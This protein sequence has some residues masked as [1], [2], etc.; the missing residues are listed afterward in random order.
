MSTQVEGRI[1]D[2]DNGPKT[3]LTRHMQ[4]F[5]GQIL[6]RGTFASDEFDRLY[7]AWIRARWLAGDIWVRSVW[8]ECP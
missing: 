1:T 2:G 3:A 8:K 5:A 7:E 4:S 6:T